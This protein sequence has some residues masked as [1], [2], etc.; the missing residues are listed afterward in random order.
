MGKIS[1]YRKR[2]HT[3]PGAHGIPEVN[4]TETY[5]PDLAKHPRARLEP[6]RQ[7]ADPSHMAHI[8]TR[9]MINWPYNP[10]SFQVFVMN[11]WI[12]NQLPGTH[13]KPWIDPQVNPQWV[14]ITTQNHN[15]VSVQHRG[16]FG[17]QMSQFTAHSILQS[18]GEMWSNVRSG[19]YGG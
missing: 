12:G 4:W 9:D 1:E 13:K 3:K 5:T 16:S 14:K 7:Y 15:P 10:A 6:L 19:N 18:V 17:P 2:R 11:G 8:A